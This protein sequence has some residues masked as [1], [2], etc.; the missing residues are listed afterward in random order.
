MLSLPADI[1]ACVSKYL[2][3]R[4]TKALKIVCRPMLEQYCTFRLQ[5]VYGFFGKYPVLTCTYLDREKDYSEQ[6]D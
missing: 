6:N 1:L 3:V 2:N 4:T 5:K